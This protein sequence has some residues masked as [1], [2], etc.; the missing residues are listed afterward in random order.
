MRHDNKPTKSVNREESRDVVSQC[1]G[2]LSDSPAG[3]LDASH[4]KSS[5]LSSTDTLSVLSRKMVVSFKGRAERLVRGAL[6]Q[7]SKM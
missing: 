1:S 6:S 3:P 5:G 4:T 7:I 2:S